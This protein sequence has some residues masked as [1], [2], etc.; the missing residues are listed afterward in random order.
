MVAVKQISKI[1]HRTG[2]SNQMPS[3]LSQAEFCFVTDTGEVMIGAGDHPKVA[4]RKSY[5]YQNIK[6]LTEFDVQRELTGDVYQNGPLTTIILPD[7][8]NK[9]SLMRVESSATVHCGIYEFNLTSQAGCITGT[10]TVN[11]HNIAGFS[12]SH[13]NYTLIGTMPNGSSPSMSL[14]TPA[15]DSSTSEIVLN[16]NLDPF[17]GSKTVLTITG[18]QWINSI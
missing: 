16:I 13:G 1:T 12:Y 4:G 6:V 3:K 7:F 8:G 9:I 10:F 14:F 11:Y 15:F 2:T 5:P 17:L 18:K